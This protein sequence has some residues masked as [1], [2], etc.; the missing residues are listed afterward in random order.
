MISLSLA[1][2]LERIEWAMSMGIS[3]FQISLPS[4]GACTEAETFTFFEHICPRF[5]LR[6]LPPYTANTDAALNR[7]M[8]SIAEEFPHWLKDE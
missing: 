8:N 5:P 4:W 1:Q 2:V 6:L 3:R 7:F